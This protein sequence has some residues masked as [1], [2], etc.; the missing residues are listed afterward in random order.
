[1]GTS[2]DLVRRAYETWND[3]DFEAAS[4]MMHPEV[5]WHSSGLFPGLPAVCHGIEEV[6]GWWTA[7]KEPWEHFTI[8]PVEIWE[9]GDR[10]ACLMQFHAAGKES[11]VGVELEFAAAWEFEEGLI[12]RYRSFVSAEEAKSALGLDAG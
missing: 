6:R 2:A 10:A 11:G 3:D 4:R 8:E 5:E 12:R 1:M 7:L 9:E